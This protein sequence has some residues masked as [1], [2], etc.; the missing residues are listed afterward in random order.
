MINAGLDDKVVIVTGANNPYGIGAAVA[1]AFA[2]Q[3]AKV[4]LHYFRDVR[5][6]HKVSSDARSPGEAFYYSQQAKSPDKLLK[7][8]H[9]IQGRADSWEADLSD[10][11]TIPALFDRAEK[12]LGPVAV[13]VNN[14]AYW[15]G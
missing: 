8:I 15:E 9:D 11:A 1:S 4:F 2:A 3:R 7:A 12:S 6:A 14:A 10:A 13:L 5:F